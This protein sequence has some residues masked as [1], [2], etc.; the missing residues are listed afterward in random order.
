MPESARGV[1]AKGSK[2]FFLASR[3]L[4][5]HTAADAQIL[6]WFCRSSDDIVDSPG[7]IHEKRAAFH[8]WVLEV[9]RALN[10]EPCANELLVALARIVT[11]HRIP[12]R[13]VE[14]FFEGLRLDLNAARYETW[15]DLSRYCYGVASTVGLMM[16]H[17][18]GFSEGALPYAIQLGL[19]M[20]LTN[21]L[22]DIGEDLANGRIYLPSAEMRRCGY[23]ESQLR[24]RERND[25]FRSLMR[26][27]I[28]RADRLYAEAEPGIDLLH[29]DARF[30]IRSASRIYQRI[31]RQIERN[32]YDVF[33][34]RAVV[35]LTRKL[36]IAAR[37]ALSA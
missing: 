32:G 23:S 20:Q 7:S 36:T 21:I 25:S 26:A 28:E 4:P 6:Y 17:V 9:N 19:A 3:F 22:R 12:V 8:S 24:A 33:G 31:L 35:P 2:S 30:A 1:M 5:R 14:E 18:I 16:S 11:T 10:G 15:S 37:A 29:A 27:E 34:Q 13:Y